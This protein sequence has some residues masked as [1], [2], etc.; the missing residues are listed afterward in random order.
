MFIKKLNFNN[1]NQIKRLILKN[2]LKIPKY[3]L[4]KKLWENNEKK[5]GE[6][7][8]NKNILVGYHSFFKK[9]IIFRKKNYNILVSSNWNVDKK[10]RGTS[11][12]L[13]NR[14]FKENCDFYITTTANET[15]SKIWRSFGALEI[16]PK[17]CRTIIFKIL[18]IK[19]FIKAYFLKKKIRVPI[20][21]I[22]IIY[23]FFKTYLSIFR[24]KKIKK[25]LN[26]QE[27]NIESSKIKN[28]NKY[29]ENKSIIP[30]EKRSN[31]SFLNYIKAIS[32]NKKIY[33]ILIKENNLVIGYSL[34]ISEKLFRPDIR[35]MYLGQIR[36][37]KDKYNYI[38][39]IFDYLSIFSRKKGC[40]LIEFRNL[41]ND[42][43]NI[44]DVN[45]FFMRNLNHNP[46]L[47]KFNNTPKNSIKKFIKNN[48]DTSYLDGDCLL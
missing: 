29:Y 27:I 43:L 14:F 30:L 20:I 36:L 28:F 48:W 1:Y 24:N 3:S 4:W 8:F 17:G 33:S 25:K 42:I 39:E 9:K 15:V 47:I 5:V 12:V 44:L 10:F 34:L 37:M 31:N 22:P 11:I 45:N 18:N 16:N 46:Y 2:R 21:F 38:D 23:L 26:Y 19:K 13:L 35:R 32:Q 6:G 40:A 41:N 7:I